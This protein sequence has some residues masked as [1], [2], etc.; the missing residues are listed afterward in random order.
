MSKPTAAF[1][2]RPTAAFSATAGSSQRLTS[3]QTVFE[4]QGIVVF[5]MVTSQS[6]TKNFA[7]KSL[8]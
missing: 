7:Y 2:L 8:Y 6:I 5:Q 1:G 3:Q 4:R